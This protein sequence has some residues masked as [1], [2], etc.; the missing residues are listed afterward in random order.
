MEKDKA[1]IDVIL[2]E[3]KKEESLPPLSRN[4]LSLQQEITKSSP[5][6]KKIENM[7][8]SDPSLTSHILRIAN[9][10]I[11]RG[12]EEIDSVKEAILRLGLEEIKNVAA[13]AI[14]QSNF[15]T[16][17]PFINTY[18]SRLWF[19]SLS[20]AAGSAWA[21]KYLDL[22][23]EAVG[24]KAFIAGLLHDMG[25][26]AL[27]TA[28]EKAASNNK[29]STYPPADKVLSGLIQRF[30]PEQGYLLL[31]HWNLPKEYCIIAR[32]HHAEDFDQSDI[33]LV[34]I[35]LINKL[36]LKMEAGNKREDTAAVVSSIES[37]ILGVSEIGI[38]EIEIEI[39]SFQ[40]K[41]K[42]KEK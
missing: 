12:L 9:S 27:L 25:S 17:D 4:A 7:I 29:I 21:A 38:A 28:L 34:L 24:S 18:K 30:H 42:R 14:H 26:L 41:F 6:I 5:D 22:D 31:K 1:I 37:N 16:K 23:T 13:W 11:Y 39:E 3:V 35:R 40:E 8:K 32:E 36:C 20:C 19:H 2:N 33:L 10:V 15:K